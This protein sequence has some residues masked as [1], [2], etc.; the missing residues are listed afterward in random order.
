M[1]RSR[2]PVIEKSR[3]RTALRRWLALDGHTYAALAELTG[4]PTTTLC[5]LANG[6]RPYPSMPDARVLREK[7]KISLEDWFNDEPANEVFG[8]PNTARAIDTESQLATEVTM[9]KPEDTSGEGSHRHPPPALPPDPNRAPA[10]PVTPSAPTF[11][12]GPEGDELP[13]R[14]RVGTR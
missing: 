14:R 13:W 8:K 2:C 12:G 6:D 9:A 7:V 11:L 4:I 5:E 3:A 1:R 10:K